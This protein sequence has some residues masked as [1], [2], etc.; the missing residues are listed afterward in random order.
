MK[1]IANAAGHMLYTGTYELQECNGSGPQRDALQC[2][3]AQG[4]HGDD[5]KRITARLSLAF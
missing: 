5:H 2:I 3:S 1:H 4:H